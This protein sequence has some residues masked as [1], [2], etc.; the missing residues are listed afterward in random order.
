MCGDEHTGFH[1]IREHLNNSFLEGNADAINSK[2]HALSHTWFNHWFDVIV[3]FSSFFPVRNCAID[4]VMCCDDEIKKSMRYK[5]NK[6]QF[7]LFCFDLCITRFKSDTF[8]WLLL[9]NITCKR[10]YGTVKLLSNY[11]MYVFVEASMKQEIQDREKQNDY[12]IRMWG[13]RVFG[14]SDVRL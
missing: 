6:F 5:C 2:I 3:F 11:H 7:A 1:S 10:I 14:Y 9:M 4:S 8:K 12:N 13:W